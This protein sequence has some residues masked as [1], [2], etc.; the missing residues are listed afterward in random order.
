VA[1]TALFLARLTYEPAA[2]NEEYIE[3]MTGYKPMDLIDGLYSVV[4]DESQ[5]SLRDRASL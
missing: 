2:D 4:Q 5:C 3:D 1:A